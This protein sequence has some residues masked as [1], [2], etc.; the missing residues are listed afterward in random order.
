MQRKMPIS[1]E[2][3]NKDT[4]QIEVVQDTF[5]D[6]LITIR[7]HRQ[8]DFKSDGRKGRRT[9]N[10]PIVETKKHS[11]FP[12]GTQEQWVARQYLIECENISIQTAPV[13]TKGYLQ[14]DRG[15]SRQEKTVN[16]LFDWA[17]SRLFDLG[18]D[19]FVELPKFSSSQKE[20]QE[21]GKHKN[22]DSNL[23]G[24][25][26]EPI[27]GT[28]KLGYNNTPPIYEQKFYYKYCNKPI[29]GAFARIQLD[30]DLELLGATIVAPKEL[31]IQHLV[32]EPNI[33]EHEILNQVKKL[34]GY[35][36]N[37][38]EWKKISNNLPIKLKWY[39]DTGYFNKWRLAYVVEN[40]LKNNSKKSDKT[41]DRN[42][43][44]LSMEVVNY[45]MDACDATLINEVRISR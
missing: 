8:Y 37:P 29:Y 5:R 28:L 2:Q 13:A 15:T 6:G 9:D 38:N 14:E 4:I 27:G 7:L 32:C 21:W 22:L 33:E 24:I 19:L 35:D 42:F 1:S 44:V 18:I 11:H 40:V 36:N 16:S 3:N 26:R 20:N 25:S 43:G 39:F 30:H 34:A 41:H 45:I 10:V 31:D 17:R 23:E 12:D